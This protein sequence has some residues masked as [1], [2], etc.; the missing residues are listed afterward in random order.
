MNKIFESL[1]SFA[2]EPYGSQLQDLFLHGSS[3]Q[4]H[5]EEGWQEEEKIVTALV[6]PDRDLRQLRSSGGKLAYVIFGDQTTEIY[7]NWYDFPSCQVYIKLIKL[8]RNSCDYKL[9]SYTSCGNKKPRFY[10][11]GTYDEAQNAWDFFQN[12][13]II[14]LS[15]VDGGV[16]ATLVPSAPPITPQRNRLCN[17]QSRPFSYASPSSPS[18]PTPG[19]PSGM[20]LAS[21][22]TSPLL[23]P[24]LYSQSTAVQ[25]TA[26]TKFF[27]I[28]VGYNPGVFTSQ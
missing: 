25:Q 15:P 4:T 7:Y 26:E 13:Q 11:Y 18:L 27:V 10:G 1:P 24:P 19:Q 21:P 6:G 2:S 8:S 28:I 5:K 20:A 22:I 9:N 3:L 16:S 12:T 17:V 14:P 23:P